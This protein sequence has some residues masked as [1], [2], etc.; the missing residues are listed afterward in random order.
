MDIPKDGQLVIKSLVQSAGRIKKV[1]LLG[2]AGKLDW[3]QT[4]AGLVIKLPATLPGNYA[5]AFK[6]E[7]KALQVAGK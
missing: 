3:Q 1:K 6:I 4:E 5:L 2:H 7:G